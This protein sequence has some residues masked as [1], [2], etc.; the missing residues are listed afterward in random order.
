M[1]HPTSSA[2]SATQFLQFLPSAAVTPS[3]SSDSEHALSHLVGH[4]SIGS[5][6]IGSRAGDEDG[7]P[8]L[9]GHHEFRAEPGKVLRICV[10]Y[11]N[12]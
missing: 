12:K 5:A 4:G 3:S 2:S 11:L 1:N 7:A 10:S 9:L 6:S 8:A